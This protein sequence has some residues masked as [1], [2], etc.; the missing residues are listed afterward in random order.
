[1][2]KP[3]IFICLVHYPVY[4]KHM[5]IVTT[6]VTNLD[7]HDISRCAT[8]YDIPGY[9][10]VHPSPSHQK[11]IRTVISYWSEGYGSL[12]N[13]DRKTA[14][15]RVIL[16]DSLEQVIDEIDADYGMPPKIVTTDARIFPN[17]V[18]F[19]WL[20]HKIR[21]TNEPILLLFGTGW[22]LEK[23]IMESADHILEPIKGVGEY[24]HLSV[25][26]AVAIILDR[27]LG[28]SWWKE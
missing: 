12:Y 10:V 19:T 14:F 5:E 16:K 6:S 28:E 7:L 17:S 21:T 23:S 18:S 27:L 8:T 11:V 25:R 22:G 1:M 15:K 24:N 20:R 2:A 9:F 13:P 26:G 4:N 3:N